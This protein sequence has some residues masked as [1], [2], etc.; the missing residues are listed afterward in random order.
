MDR[1]IEKNPLEVPTFMVERQIEFMMADT[2]R[3][4]LAQGSSL[5]Q[6]GVS[7]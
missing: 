2:Q 6:L 4:L 5:E 7:A 3:A 1:L